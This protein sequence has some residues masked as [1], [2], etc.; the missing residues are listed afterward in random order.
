MRIYVFSVA[1]LA[2][3]MVFNCQLQAAEPNA[4]DKTVVEPNETAIAVTVDGFD[5]TEGQVEASIET[6]LERISKQRPPAFVQQY[7]KQLMQQATDRMVVEHLLDEAVK[8]ANIEVNDQEVIDHIKKIAAQQQPPLSLE[9]FKQLISAYGKS[10][11]EA[12]EQIHKGLGYQKLM[13]A[14]FA[15][16]INVAEDDAKKYYSENTKQFEMPE[17]VRASHILIK[18]DVTD[19]NIDPNQA[20]A[21]AKRK[22]ED[23]LKQIKEGADFAELAKANSACPSAEKSGDLGFFSKGQMV[24]AFEKA[25]FGLKTGQVSDIVETQ[26]GYHIVKL[27]DRKEAGVMPFEQV[28][29]RILEML[30]QDKQSQLAKEYVESLKAKAKIVY[31]VGKEPIPEPNSP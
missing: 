1:I 22:A 9:E 6:Q 29:D 26:F 20:K 2:S 24:P 13:E 8:A 12:K 23:L 19:P 18:P 30:K 3:L 25:A 10:F 31:P 15:G 7:K 16:K 5:I 17:Q 14:Q 21:K 11:D 28:K 4:A 27:T